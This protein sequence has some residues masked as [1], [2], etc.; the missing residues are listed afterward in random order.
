MS[1]RYIWV[2]ASL[3]GLVFLIASCADT[4]HVGNSKTWDSHPGDMGNDAG[5]AI[6]NALHDSED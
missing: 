3:V 6:A 5:A 4:K 1:E 2:I